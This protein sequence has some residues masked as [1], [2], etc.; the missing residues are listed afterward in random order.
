MEEWINFLT[1]F[2]KG[3][4]NSHLSE[5]NKGKGVF[6][7]SEIFDLEITLSTKY[8]F[9]EIIFPNNKVQTDFLKY[10]SITKEVTDKGDMNL[11]ETKWNKNHFPCR[12]FVEN[13]KIQ[14]YDL[15]NDLPDGDKFEKR[16]KVIGSLFSILIELKLQNSLP[17]N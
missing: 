17:M 14:F 12:V 15:T 4:C 7:T 8:G 13:R 2:T 1:D 3:I 11:V 9:L 10:S 16:I 6:E 5:N